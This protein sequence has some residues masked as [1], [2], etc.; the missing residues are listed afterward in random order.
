M[1]GVESRVR[2]VDYIYE[3]GTEV[4]ELARTNELEGIVAKWVAARTSMAN[5][6]A[7]SRSRTRGIRKWKGDT[8]C[9]KRDDHD[10]KVR[11]VVCVRLRSCSPKKQVTQPPTRAPAIPPWPPRPPYLRF[12]RPVRL[13]SDGTC[14]SS[15]SGASA[16]LAP[17]ACVP[18]RS[19]RP[20]G[21]PIRNAPEC[22]QGF[23]VSRNQRSWAWLS[24]QALYR[25]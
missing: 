15:R 14:R 8:S 7:G 18:R 6:Q 4:F 5:P 3:R 17:S 10:R 2:Y 11:A 21:V 20:F 9:S 19:C 22:A 1:P 16:P 24:V 13:R 23:E 12:D 25:L